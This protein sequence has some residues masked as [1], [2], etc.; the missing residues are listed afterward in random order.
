M[1]SVQRVLCGRPWPLLPTIGWTTSW[2]SWMSIASDRVRL[3]PCS[4]TWRPTASAAKLLGQFQTSSTFYGTPVSSFEC[5][6]SLISW[7]LVKLRCQS[8]P[9]DPSVLPVYFEYLICTLFEGHGLYLFKM[10]FLFLK[11]VEHLCRRWP[12]CGGA[13]QSFLASPES[14]GQTHMHC[15]KDIQGQRAQKWVWSF[16]IL[17][18]GKNNPLYAEYPPILHLKILK[19]LTTGTVSPSPRTGLKMF[20]KTWKLRSKSPTK[21]CALNCLKRILHQQTLAP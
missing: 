1:E 10:F 8:Q 19:I 18:T 12:Q 4:M 5:Q 9:F 14:S 20:W 21:P 16:D 7:L 15:C 3:H 2:P 11:K 13:V 17:L 6:L